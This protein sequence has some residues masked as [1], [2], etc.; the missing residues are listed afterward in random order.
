LKIEA[1]DPNENLAI[2]STNKVSENSIDPSAKLMFERKVLFF[3][4][5]GHC[6]ACF[7]ESISLNHIK[8][9]DCFAP[10]AMAISPKISLFR[11]G[12]NNQIFLTY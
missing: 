10:L 2:E 11:S 9:R 1:A 4:F 3:K 7:A 8:L 5:S 6:E 12:T